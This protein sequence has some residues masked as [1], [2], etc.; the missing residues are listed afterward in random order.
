MQIHI[1]KQ[2]R[3]IKIN[4]TELNRYYIIITVKARFIQIVISRSKIL[5]E[6]A[7]DEHSDYPN[8]KK[9]YAVL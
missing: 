4:L 5:T 3:I 9:N 6:T 1:S 8:I 2:I 7:F